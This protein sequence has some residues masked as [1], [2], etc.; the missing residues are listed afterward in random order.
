MS[1]GHEQTARDSLTIAEVEAAGSWGR[2]SL[3]TGDI[4][5]PSTKKIGAG[6]LL[7]WLWLMC[8]TC[9]QL[10][11]RLSLIPTSPGGQ[12]LAHFQD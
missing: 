11:F 3:F 1:K 5:S 10:A 9:G 12:P 7:A 4:P 2:G 8:E 6:W